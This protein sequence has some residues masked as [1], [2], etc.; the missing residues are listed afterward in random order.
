MSK[1]PRQPRYAQIFKGDERADIAAKV[2]GETIQHLQDNDLLSDR[3]VA[4]ADR[5]ARAYAEYEG[6]YP[7]VV[8][9]GPITVGPNGGDVFN[10]L[11][12]ACEKLNE[13][14]AKFEDALLIS[15]KSAGGAVKEKRPDAKPTAA[16]E[17]L[18][19]RP[20]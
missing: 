4:V 1:K 11:W 5:Y 13:R 15:P 16:D 18:A 7:D 3:R 19:P 8:E 9:K 14:I 6:M 10:G 12:S 17:F 20:N 2:W